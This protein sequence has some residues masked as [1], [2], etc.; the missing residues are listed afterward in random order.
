MQNFS[1]GR[2]LIFLVVLWLFVKVFS[3]KF[4]SVASLARQKWAICKSFLVF[5]INSCKFS[6]SKVFAVWY[7]LD[8]MIQWRKRLTLSAVLVYLAR[9]GWLAILPGWAGELCKIRLPEKLKW[10]SWKVCLCKECWIL[11]QQLIL[12]SCFHFYCAM[13]SLDY[14]LWYL[15]CM[16]DN[17]DICWPYSQAFAAKH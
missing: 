10:V 3:T 1:L 13:F 12:F 17:V 16:I 14:D 7:S 5:F 2:W 4:G 11:K 9:C 15:E 6:P 8:F